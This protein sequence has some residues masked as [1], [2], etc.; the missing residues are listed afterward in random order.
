MH[1]KTSLFVFIGLLIWFLLHPE[2]FKN[3]ER[4]YEKNSESFIAARVAANLNYGY[5]YAGGLLGQ[6]EFNPANSIIENPYYNDIESFWNLQFRL[7]KNFE[8]KNLK[9]T[10]YYSQL[11][12]HAYGI[13]FLSNLF[14]Y[15]FVKVLSLIILI[16]LLTFVLF[17]VR[18]L[19]G[20][21]SYVGGLISI[22]L[23][24]RMVEIS[25]NLYWVIWITLL[26]MVLNI[27]VLYQI[28]VSLRFKI[29]LIAVLNF[30]VLFFINSFRY[31]FVSATMVAMQIPLI[32]YLIHR[33]VGVNFKSIGA[34][35]LT[36]ASAVLGFLLALGL[37]FK[38]IESFLGS[39]KMALE[40]FNS[41]IYR[42]TGVGGEIEV[43]QLIQKSLNVDFV[44]VLEL[45]FSL[46]MMSGLA[47]NALLI[48]HIACL[49]Y[50]FRK[51]SLPGVNFNYLPLA[52]ILSLAAPLSWLILAKGHSYIHG[53]LVAQLFY[54]PY[55]ILLFAFVGKVFS[56]RK[57]LKS[58]PK[59]L[60]SLT[61][62]TLRKL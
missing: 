24:N 5:S 50:W 52:S 3:R 43:H 17:W 30:V 29:L 45:Y 14:G 55:T 41:F 13:A 49:I 35:I 15:E 12:L 28:K 2:A 16:G 47:W 37:H 23:A 6:F 48:I 38:V 44:D 11:G 40:I 25:Q 39:Q 1:K 42:R 56:V 18:S 26:P 62:D 32:L 9:F 10:P 51:H 7:L 19:W 36:G 33:K 27:F 58:T 21:E 57:F 22:L 20:G 53:P 4:E 46:S 61:G 8:D 59:F 54:F 34:F 60:P 31:E